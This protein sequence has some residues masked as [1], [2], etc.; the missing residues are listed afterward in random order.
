MSRVSKEK[1]RQVQQITKEGNKFG[2]SDWLKSEDLIGL[3]LAWPCK[4]TLLTAHA[5]TSTN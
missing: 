3:G 4:K 1:E 5:Q 2:S